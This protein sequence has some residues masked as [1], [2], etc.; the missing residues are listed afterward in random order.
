MTVFYYPKQSNKN[1]KL[2]SLDKCLTLG[3]FYWR[4]RHASISVSFPLFSLIYLWVLFIFLVGLPG[5]LG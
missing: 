2:C 3:D 1:V 5:G 4:H